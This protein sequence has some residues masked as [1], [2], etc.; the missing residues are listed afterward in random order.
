MQAMDPACPRVLIPDVGRKSECF[1]FYEG[2]TVY[3]PYVP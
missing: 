1:Q 3:T 2:D